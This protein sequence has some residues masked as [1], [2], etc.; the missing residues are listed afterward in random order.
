VVLNGLVITVAGMAI[1]FVFLILLVLSMNA[2]F[3]FVKKFFPGS[4][5]PTKE[6]RAEMQKA[7]APAPGA[8]AAGPQAVPAEVVAAIAAAKTYIMNYRG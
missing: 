3:A 1:V 5:E 4:L 8:A 2:L 6:E 7:K